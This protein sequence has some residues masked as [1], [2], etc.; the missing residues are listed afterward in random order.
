MIEEQSSGSWLIEDVNPFE[1]HSILVEKVLLD[2]STQYQK[3]QLVRLKGFGLALVLDGKIQSSQVDE[4]IYHEC[5]VHPA[6]LMVDKPKSVLVIGGGEGATLREIYRY[7][8][9]EKIVMVDIDGEVVEAC[10]KHLNEFHQGAFDDPRTELVID[11]ARAFVKN[12]Q[13]SF[14]VIISDISEAL[15]GT[16]AAYMFTSDFYQQ[17]QSLLQPGG[18]MSMQSGFMRVDDLD[19]FLRF[20]ATLRA[21]FTNRVHSYVT[22]M[23][24]YNGPWAFQVIAPQN[25]PAFISASQ[26]DEKLTALGIADQLKFYDGQAHHHISN[27]PKYVRTEMAKERAIF[28]ADEKPALFRPQV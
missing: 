6:M 2:Q 20:N 16:T 14:D 11:D 28:T 4:F 22:N 26:V 17:A 23:I 25:N 21:T 3:L 8:S 10:R 13:Q 27:I 24:S 15:E 5:L 7:P 19:F 12:C 18:A 1:K 9:I